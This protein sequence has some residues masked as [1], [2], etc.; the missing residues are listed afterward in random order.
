MK[1]T[2]VLAAA[3]GLALIAIVGVFIGYVTQ[4]L[5]QHTPRLI[6]ISAPATDTPVGKKKDCH[7]CELTREEIQTR[8][9]KIVNE[10]RHLKTLS[11]LSSSESGGLP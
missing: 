4:T 3:C 8:L 5:P 10:K 11:P 9:K 7:C 2:H 1:D 6:T